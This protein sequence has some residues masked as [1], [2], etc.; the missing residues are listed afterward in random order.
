[1][2]ARRMIGDIMIVLAVGFTA[3]LSVVMRRRIGAVVL[4]D[5]YKAVFRYE[6][7]VCACF[8][9]FALD[10]RFGFLT[11][12]KPAALKA[13][14]W[15]T[16]V[17]VAL[18]TAVF[19]F[20]IGKITVG[21]FLN[22]QA[23]AARAVVLGLALENGGPTEDLMSRLEVAAAYWRQNPETTLILTGGN[24]DAS[25]RTEAAVMRDILAERGVARERMILEDQAENTRE[26]FQNTAR[27]VDPDEPV[28][29][30]SS[31]YHMDRAVQ[32]ARRA[33]FSRVLRLPA[34]SSR[35][36][37]GA[38]VMWETVIELNELTLRQ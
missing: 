20:F 30:I 3:Y 37:F 22:T 14:G 5:I 15:G 2:N 6:L 29:L 18:A 4:K 1:M 8:I 10:V 28:V 9:L 7:I 13:V 38:N 24:P 21:S 12:P 23:P 16:R 27:L 34:P 17:M 31:D 33:G 32:T 19:L 25:G 26:N 36:L 11:G 35:G